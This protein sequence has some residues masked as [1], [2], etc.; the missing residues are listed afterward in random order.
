MKLAERFR[1]GWNAFINGEREVTP[2]EESGVRWYEVSSGQ[3]SGYTRLSTVN[4]RSII[5]AVLNRIAVDCAQVDIRHV[6]FDEN[7]RFLNYINSG[8][9]RCLTLTANIDQTGRDFIQ[10][11]VLRMLDDG[12]A[13]VVPVDCES[14]P[15][16]GDRIDVLTM[17][18]GTVVEWFPRHIRVD[19]YNDRTGMHEQLLMPKDSVCIMVNP[20]YTVMNERNSTMQ[21]LIRKLNLLD[22]ID[23]KTGSDRVDMII[24][25][26]YSVKT[27]SMRARAEQRRRDIEVQLAGSKYGIA[28]I[29]ATEHVT[30][31]NRSVENQLLGQVEYLQKLF[32]SQLG[33]TEEILNGSASEDTMQNYYAR[34][35]EPILTVIAMEFERK[36]L[37]QAAI[38]QRQ[39]VDFF[40]DPFKLVPVS[41]IAD[42]ADKLTR[43]AILSSNEMRGI[44]GYKP[45]DDPDAD[46]LRNKNLN[47]SKEAESGNVT[48]PDATKFREK[49]AGPAENSK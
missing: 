21:R 38:T 3:R 36:C 35:V 31:L 37:S 9:D 34:L 19:L 33:V 26:P 47:Q 42:V 14:D 11:I 22:N 43:N 8:L 4:E 16:T 24:Q 12:V 46:S 13:V 41:K 27:E 29:D 20:F 45:V 40:M 39:A 48:I 6:R 1:N 32:F 44:I 49:P 30:Q 2:S 5:N 18:V 10:D 17:R 15:N 7:G 25:L 23:A 28:Y